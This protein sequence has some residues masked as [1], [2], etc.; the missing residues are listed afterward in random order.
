MGSDWK[1]G[2]ASFVVRVTRTFYCLD[3]DV[4]RMGDAFGKTC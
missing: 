4:G 1:G 3:R 2:G